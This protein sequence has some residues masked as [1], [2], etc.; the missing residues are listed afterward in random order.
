MNFEEYRSIV[1][2]VTARRLI[3]VQINCTQY[4]ADYDHSYTVYSECTCNGRRIF[5]NNCTKAATSSTM[6]HSCDITPYKTVFFIRTLY[7]AS[8][9]TQQHSLQPVLLLLIEL[10]EHRTKCTVQQP[11][12]VRTD[13]EQ[14]KVQWTLCGVGATDWM[15]AVHNTVIRIFG[16]VWINC[17]LRE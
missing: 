6:S 5:R 2:R 4:V 13:S 1:T 17:I 7:F 11:F 9:L 15:V 8:S 12:T 3:A 14:W 16:C 10:T